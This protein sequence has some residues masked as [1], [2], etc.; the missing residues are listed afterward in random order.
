MDLHNPANRDVNGS[1]SISTHT[2]DQEGL[3][4]NGREEG[5][6]SGELELG[7][8]AATEEEAYD[9]EYTLSN[10]LRHFSAAEGET[11]S[12][13]FELVSEGSKSELVRGTLSKQLQV[14]E[15]MDQEVHSQG[16]GQ[17]DSDII[18]HRMYEGER[19]PHPQAP[20]AGD[21]RFPN[22][23]ERMLD[24]DDD[25]QDLV[26]FNDLEIVLHVENDTQDL[27]S[28]IEWYDPTSR[29]WLPC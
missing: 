8:D 25:E 3:S 28:L 10:N 14:N 23:L 22:D 17:P 26:F 15:N 1:D 18:Q 6:E 11:S 5:A 24:V 16:Q 29:R 27:A 4:D 12:T 2:C 9:L 20:D 7:D 19:V 13:E 21:D